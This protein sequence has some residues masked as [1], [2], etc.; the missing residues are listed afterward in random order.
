MWRHPELHLLH[1]I[2]YY[3]M[4]V[5]CIRKLYN[6]VAKDALREILSRNFPVQFDKKRLFAL[7]LYLT[8]IIA[9][10]C[11]AG[12]TH[13]RHLSTVRKHLSGLVYSCQ[14]LVPV[15]PENEKSLTAEYWYSLS[16]DDK[17]RFLVKSYL[18]LP[19]TMIMRKLSLSYPQ[20]FTMNKGIH[21]SG[22]WCSL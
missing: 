5:Y 3:N 14:V 16:D 18:S 8:P 19:S 20:L 9:G 22:W 2:S 15:P 10:F 13:C 1:L 11:H 17:V 21:I 12:L 7:S 4:H 6:L